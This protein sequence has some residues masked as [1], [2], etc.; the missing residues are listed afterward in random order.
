MRK[1][2]GILGMGSI[3]SRHASNLRSLG[4]EVIWYDPM[5]E[6]GSSYGDVVDK[7]DAIVIASP[8]DLHYQQLMD[9]LHTKKPIFCEKPIAHVEDERF[10][11]VMMVGYNLRFHP[12][13][14]VAKNDW[15]AASS[16]GIGKVLWAH[17]TCGQY[18]DKYTDNVILNWSHEI[19]LALYL[20]G[21]A[22]C[23]SCNT[24]NNGRIAD[25]ALKHSDDLTSYVHLDYVSRPELRQTIIVGTEGQIILDIA[26]RAAWLRSYEGKLLD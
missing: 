7:T 16:G 10:K 18:N 26:N 6:D 24:S 19:D 23:V 22:E 11:N 2:F 17:F 4:H 1:I 20:L 13:V 3:G 21:P 25:L 8:T 9:A 12:C 5:R 15:L 14:G